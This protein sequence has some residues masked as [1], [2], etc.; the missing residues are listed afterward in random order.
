MVLF[1]NIALA[2]FMGIRG[3]I[4]TWNAGLSGEYGTINGTVRDDNISVSDDLGIGSYQSG[5]FWFEVE[6]PFPA[7]PNFRVLYTKI[8][9]DGSKILTRNISFVQNNT[10][11]ATDFVEYKV[12]LDQFDFTT[13]WELSDSFLEL[14]IGFNLKYL[15]GELRLAGDNANNDEVRTFREFF[16]MAYGR[17]KL[18]MP[19]TNMGL[20]VEGSTTFSGK[21]EVI[22]Q[23]KAGLLLEG[24][25]VGGELGYRQEILKFTNISDT[26]I[27]LQLGGFYGAVYFHF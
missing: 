2:D 19:D 5:F 27:D 4:G 12:V 25:A 26:F 15:T 20:V 18:I 24:Y 14:D 9:Y 6:H 17:A 3:G 23:Y 13:Y 8:D 10:F 16:P 7:I 21:D 1:V 11:Q 22:S